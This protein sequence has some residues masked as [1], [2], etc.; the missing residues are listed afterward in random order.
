MC[1]ENVLVGGRNFNKFKSGDVSDKCGHCVTVSGPPVTSYVTH[2]RLPPLC[3]ISKSVRH[4]QC[5]KGS[6]R[7]LN[8]SRQHKCW[9][10]GEIDTLVV[11]PSQLRC[12]SAL[13]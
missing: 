6:I 13:I 3:D 10:L 1:V 4:I 9:W 12:W 7:F 11:R 8:Q 2:Y 5:L